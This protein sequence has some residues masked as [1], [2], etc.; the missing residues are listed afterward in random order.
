MWDQL[1]ETG[2]PA[3]NFEYRLLVICFLATYIYMLASRGLASR[4]S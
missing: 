3:T 1:I 4:W 2:S